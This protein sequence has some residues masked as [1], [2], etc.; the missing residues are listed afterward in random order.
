M[1]KSFLLW[2]LSFFKS[3]E[4]KAVDKKIEEIDN[5]IKEIENEEPTDDDLLDR[6][7]K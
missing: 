7:N 4:E 1:I 3:D 6:L 2:L 5:K